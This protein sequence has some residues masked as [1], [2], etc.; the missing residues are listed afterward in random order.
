MSW[1]RAR[2]LFDCYRI[3]SLFADGLTCL[4]TPR[5]VI[6]PNF[7]DVAVNRL[8]PVYRE[9]L[10]FRT[11]THQ[12]F[13]LEDD[14][15][16]QLTNIG[17]AARD[18]L[19]ILG[20]VTQLNSEMNVHM[21]DENSNVLESFDKQRSALLEFLIQLN[22]ID[23]KASREELEARFDEMDL[24]L[25]NSEREATDEIERKLEEDKIPAEMGASL[26]SVIVLVRSI[27]HQLIRA[28]RHFS[29][30]AASYDEVEIEMKDQL[31][32]DAAEVDA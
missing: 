9:L 5:E 27:C 2:R 21:N 11:K 24:D 26:F 12:R 20:N 16:R 1:V 8:Q 17:N 32:A 10:A 22:E 14:E 7:E 30:A 31:I 29:D 6:S 15:S 3:L 23:I 25:Q 4:Y 13:T 19:L 28:T 18:A